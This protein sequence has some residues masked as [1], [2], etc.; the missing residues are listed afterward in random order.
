MPNL[1]QMFHGTGDRQSPQNMHDATKVPRCGLIA[2]RR[3]KGRPI[4]CLFSA[5]AYSRLQISST[6]LGRLPSTSIDEGF[7]LLPPK[8]LSIDLGSR[9]CEECAQCARSG[10]PFSPSSGISK[11]SAGFPNSHGR[12]SAR[13]SGCSIAGHIPAIRQTRNRERN[14]FSIA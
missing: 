2:C 11:W 10:L 1:S 14:S 9:P 6:K 7:R 5:R 3:A 8:R 13:G 4:G 12:R